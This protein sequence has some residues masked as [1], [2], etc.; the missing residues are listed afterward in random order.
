M[1]V[2]MLKNQKKKKKK[3]KTE[4]TNPFS[5]ICMLNI[6]PCSQ[7]MPT[8]LGEARKDRLECNKARK[9]PE[10]RMSI[11][12]QVPDNYCTGNVQHRPFLVLV[13]VPIFPIFW[14]PVPVFWL[15]YRYRTILIIFGTGTHFSHLS[16]LVPC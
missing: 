7:S 1:F 13:P 3:K 14:E 10:P 11:W 6:N 4:K 9:A 2:F 12:Y 15:I 8:R 5:T 16:V